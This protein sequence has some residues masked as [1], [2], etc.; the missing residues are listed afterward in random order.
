MNGNPNDNNEY[1]QRRPYTL[2]ETIGTT[3]AVML[4]LG[5][6]FFIVIWGALL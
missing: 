6:V 5:P 1:F 3:I 4:F 2:A